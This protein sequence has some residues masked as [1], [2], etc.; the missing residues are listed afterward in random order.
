MLSLKA[1]LPRDH[2]ETKAAL[3]SFRL[4]HAPTVSLQI[5]RSHILSR[6]GT[7]LLEV[8]NKYHFLMELGFYSKPTSGLIWQ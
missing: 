7:D 1:N 6:E 3:P 4:V 2:I 8:K 5:Q